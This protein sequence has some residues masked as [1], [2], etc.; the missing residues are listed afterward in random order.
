MRRNP[1]SARSRASVE[2]S[3]TN[4]HVDFIVSD[5]GPGVDPGER[6]LVFELG[7]RGSAAPTGSGGA[8]LGLALSRRLAVAL[9]GEVDGLVS[10]SGARFRVRLPLG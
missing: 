4:G 5:D 7:E 2:V 3:A 10:E 6:G 9:G 8:G 1:H